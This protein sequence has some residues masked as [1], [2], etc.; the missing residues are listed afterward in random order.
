MKK[1]YFKNS[2]PEIEE[3]LNTYKGIYSSYISQL[4]IVH[5]L[6]LQHLEFPNK[7]RTYGLKMALTSLKRLAVD[8][9]REVTEI[10]RLVNTR[11]KERKAIN[12]VHREQVLKRREEKKK[13]LKNDNN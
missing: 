12:R 8:L 11:D 3:R 13:E 6:Y 10:Q 7:K 4:C 9:Q 5:N 1:R 2:T